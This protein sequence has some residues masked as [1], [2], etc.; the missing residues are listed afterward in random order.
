LPPPPLPATRDLSVPSRTVHLPLSWDD[1]ATRE[2]TERYMA[3]VRA[4]A[5][6][7]PWNIEFIRRVNGLAS[8][9]DV[10]RTVFDAEYLVLGLGDVYLG[11]P[12]ATPLD[13]R[14]RL[15]TTKYNPART[16]TPENAVGIG[17]AYLCI[18]G[19]EGPGGYQFV[20]R[21]VQVWS[22][23][24][25]F[26]Q[27][28]PYLLRFFDRIVWHPVSAEEL[29]EQRAD[30]AAGRLELRIDDGA[31]RLADHLAFL[32]AEAEGIAAFRA[33][34]ATAFSAERAAWAAA[35]EFDPRPDPVVAAASS[36]PSAA[37][38]PP[39]ATLVEAPLSASVWKVDVGP[40]DTVRAGDRLLTLEAMK[41]ETSIDSPV[42]GEVLDV[43]V[44]A[45]AQV[46]SGTALLVL[47]AKVPA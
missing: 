8:V 17:G 46:D 25:P 28:H 30:M 7:C 5:P 24:R 4:D 27:G 1:P 41:T 44:T 29:L 10:Y 47:G 2:A 20:G 9:D 33:R 42:D 6:W 43:L 32:D 40:G 16:W 23:F 11:A 21:T 3:G 14:H 45:G 37:D 39:G 34:Q 18:Y 38:L 35:G 36:G 19:M 26:A 13:P 15:V 12:V 31:F 22:R